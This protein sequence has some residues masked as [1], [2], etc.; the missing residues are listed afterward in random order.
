MK[1]LRGYQQLTVEALW[2]AFSG[3]RESALIVLASGLGK[4]VVSAHFSAKWVKHMEEGGQILFLAHTVDILRQAR[5]EFREELPP[6]TTLSVTTSVESGDKNA[7]LRFVTFQSMRTEFSEDDP[8]RYRLIIVDEAHHGG[9]ETYKEIITH[10]SPYFKIGMTATP[11]RMDGYDIR[12]LFGEP[13]FEYD[14][15]KALAE[16]IWLARL[17]YHLLTDNI[18][19]QALKK[20]VEEVDSSRSVSKKQLDS[21]LFLE[22]RLEEI[23]RVVTKYQGQDNKKKTIIFCRSI[24]HLEVVQEFFPEARPYY[25]GLHKKDRLARLERFRQG[26]LSTILVIDMFN[27]GIDIPDAELVVFMRATDS[28]TVWLQ[29]MG[30]GLRRTKE[31]TQ[32]TVLDF[33]AN[34][35]RILAVKD[36]QI[37]VT[38]HGEGETPETL[39][40]SGL[41]VT[42]S[43]TVEDILYILSYLEADFYTYQEASK[44]AIELIEEYGLKREQ[45]SHK[46]IYKLDLRLPSCPDVTYKTSGW[47]DWPTFLK[48]FYTYEEASERAIELIEEYGLKREQ[49]SY[50]QIYKLDSRLPSDP[51]RSYKNSGWVDWYIFLDKERK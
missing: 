21:V 13:V 14:L 48:K 23:A 51:D 16:D 38:K 8:E 37:E 4:T 40:V 28:K 17:D 3:E 45:R 18:D 47:V 27:E 6:G 32:V 44:R 25:S 36:L 30:R 46:Q 5:D 24:E 50:K 7:Q 10:Y 11:D 39:R 35:D 42:F 29:Q 26:T 9:A 15:P 43:D 41:N 22:E 33:V 20:L 1:D 34:T 49:K 19:T 12:D 31:K 2:N